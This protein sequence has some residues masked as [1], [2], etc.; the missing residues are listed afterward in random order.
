VLNS[1]AFIHV[2]LPATTVL[3]EISEK[4]DENP[5]SSCL[6]IFDRN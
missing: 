1:S 2:W 4:L 3:E 6:L 5:A